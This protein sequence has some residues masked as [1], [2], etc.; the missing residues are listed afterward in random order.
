MEPG[1]ENQDVRSGVMPGR[2]RFTRL[3]FIIVIILAASALILLFVPAVDR[4]VIIEEKT[5]RCLF[6]SKVKPGDSFI[7]GYIHSVNKSPV[8]DF[9]EIG[10]DLGISLKKTVFRSF[11]AGIPF[12]IEKNQELKLYRDRLEIEN[13]NT[14]IEDLLL[15]VGTQA[16]HTFTMNNR[17]L[18]LNQLTSPQTT[19]RFEVR[20]LPLFTLFKGDKNG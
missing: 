11:G 12:D 8:E 20:K 9:F 7:I 17:K 4:L 13:I 3:V 18:H 6:V 10:E 19:V 16:D 1:F 15:F 5:G 2:L 14:E